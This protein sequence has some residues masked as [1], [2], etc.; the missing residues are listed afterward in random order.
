MIDWQRLCC[1]DIWS[2]TKGRLFSNGMRMDQKFKGDWN[3]M[4]GV[5]IE[6]LNR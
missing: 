6:A 3:F 4:G 1:S 2:Q 5:K